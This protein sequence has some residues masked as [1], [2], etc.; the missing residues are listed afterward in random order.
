MKQSIY[1]FQNARPD[2]FDPMCHYFAQQS[3][4]YK[5]KILHL[6]QSF[7]STPP[8]LKLVDKVFNNFCQEISFNT[9]KI[10]HEIFRKNDP[11][12]VEIWPII[13]I[14]NNKSFFIES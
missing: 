13:N 3:S 6:T 8:I 10:K 4:Q 7:R 2:Y 1:G 12:Y 14:K 5:H 9:T 11:G